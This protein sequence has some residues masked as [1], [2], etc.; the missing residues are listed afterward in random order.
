M[1]VCNLQVRIGGQ[2]DATELCHFAHQNTTLESGPNNDSRF[3]F[4]RCV[5]CQDR[6][7]SVTN[8][9]GHLLVYFVSLVAVARSS[10]ALT[11]RCRSLITVD[12]ATP[13][14]VQYIAVSGRLTPRRRLCTN[15]WMW[16]VS[17]PAI[18][19][20]SRSDAEYTAV[21]CGC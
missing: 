16:T 3:R 11:T 17:G 15:I 10:A 9:E 18:G 12:A 7:S 2:E 21:M 1:A 14:L 19:H 13:P 20:L 5:T 4:M 8:R 6:Q